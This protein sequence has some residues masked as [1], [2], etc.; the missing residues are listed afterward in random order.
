[1][2]ST[3]RVHQAGKKLL[4]AHQM[5]GA[6]RH[7]AT[8]CNMGSIHWQCSESYSK[9]KLWIKALENQSLCKNKPLK[10]KALESPEPDITDLSFWNVHQDGKAGYVVA[11]AS[12]MALVS[13]KQLTSSGGPGTWTTNPVWR[14]GISESHPLTSPHLPLLSLFGTGLAPQPERTAST[15]TEIFIAVTCLKEYHQLK[16]LS[17]EVVSDTTAGLAGQTLWV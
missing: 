10:P 11:L 1:M 5:M 15:K 17:A 13:G 14:K 8:H 9:L 7:G 2:G 6:I 4:S 12:D 3:Q 16:K